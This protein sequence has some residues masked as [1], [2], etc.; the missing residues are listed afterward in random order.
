[1]GSPALAAQPELVAA[2][3]GGEWGVPSTAVSALIDLGQGQLTVDAIQAELARDDPHR[4]NVVP[5]IARLGPLAR[6]CLPRLKEMLAKDLARPETDQIRSDKL[7]VT[8]ALHRIAPAEID[9]LPLYM[10]MAL[11][12][13]FVSSTAIAFLGELGTKARPAVPLLIDAF[14][15][16]AF[17]YPA[18][19]R[20]PAGRL[21][22]I[23]SL[24][25]ESLAKICD[26]PAPELLALLN[27]RNCLRRADAAYSLGRFGARAAQHSPELIHALKDEFV[28]VR[29]EAATALGELGPDAK[30]SVE[31][32]AA[33]LGDEFITVRESALR[34]L[35]RL[36]PAAIAAKPRVAELQ[37]D[38]DEQLR[39]QAAT[40]L[41]EWSKAE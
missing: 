23:G 2:M 35:A 37:N 1:M 38:P 4:M 6:E 18:D 12:D 7:H 22:R 30:G 5:Q 20:Y 9:P 21:R 19:G 11:D 29:A 16:S 14:R 31:A 15:S 39:K 36:G 28:I 32:L 25:G 41:A 24:A 10:E 13:P 26:V 27:H 40:L 3:N 8:H 34:A 33:A 17:A